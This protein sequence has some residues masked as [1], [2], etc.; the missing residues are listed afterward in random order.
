M[1]KNNFQPGKYTTSAL[2]HIFHLSERIGGR[3]SCTVNERQAGEYAAGELMAMG[4]SG[5]DQEPFKA[6]PATYWPFALGFAA[7]LAGT[8]LALLAGGRAA[9]TAA[10]SLNL[11]GVW[12]MLAETEFTNHWAR[13][14]LP[15][16]PSQNVTGVIPSKKTVQARVVLC[17][18]LDTHRT[19]VFF[20]SQVWYS[21]FSLLLT[22]T[23]LSMAA[24]AVVFGLGAILAWPAARWIALF[25]FPMQV[26]SLA[27][28]LHADFTPYSPG[29]ND[30]ASG[31]GVILGLVQRLLVERLENTQVHLAFTGCEEV[32]SYGIQAYLDRHSQE[33][34][35][36]VV[37]IILDEVGIG[38][39]KYLTA[40]GLVLKHKTHPRALALGREISATHPDLQVV[41]RTGLAYTDALSVTKRGLAA[42]TVCTEVDPKA[43]K[44]SH[45]HQMSDT[46]E[47]L[48]PETL[49]RAHKFIWEILQKIDQQASTV[50]F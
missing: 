22:L 36:Q 35:D 30:D 14:F 9:L 43:E 4:M 11:L 17:A 38:K 10:A 33:L 2:S 1:Q 12:A 29:A 41:E 20:S 8:L 42:L 23:F 13:W 45:W 37:Y 48:Q 15:R 44:V 7:S 40:D 18:H 6:I 39:I 19:P 28:C 26:F 50:S 34:G 46:I 3:G 5:V 32:G 25:A 31:V 49:D 16:R 27:M 24:G 47:T 21:V